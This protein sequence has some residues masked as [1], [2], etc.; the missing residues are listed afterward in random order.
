MSKSMVCEQGDQGFTMHFVRNRAGPMPETTATISQDENLL[1]S[2]VSLS[3]QNLLTYTDS[4]NRFASLVDAV[5][6]LRAREG[7]VV[8]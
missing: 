3:A 4:S 8:G 1:F 6:E 5:V 7:S 2:A